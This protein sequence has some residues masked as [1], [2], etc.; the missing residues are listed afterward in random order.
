MGSSGIYSK[1]KAAFATFSHYKQL[2]LNTYSVLYTANRHSDIFIKTKAD[3][4]FANYST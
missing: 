1:T 4:H 3:F 2:Q